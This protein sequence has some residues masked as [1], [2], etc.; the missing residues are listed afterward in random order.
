M[1]KVTLK[2]FYTSILP[3]FYDIISPPVFKVLLPTGEWTVS[4][5]EAA[6]SHI[7]GINSQ[8]KSDFTFYGKVLVDKCAMYIRVTLY[9]GYLIIL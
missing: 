2:W 4:P 6:V 5:L 3:C 8:Y 9:C 7:H 1:Q